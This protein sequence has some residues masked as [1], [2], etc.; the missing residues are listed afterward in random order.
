MRLNEHLNPAFSYRTWSRT[1]ATCVWVH[2]SPRR[3]R[4]CDHTAD[5]SLRRAY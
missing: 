5:S 2:W 1:G 3:N 4:G